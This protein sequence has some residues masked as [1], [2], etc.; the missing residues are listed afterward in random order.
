MRP[1]DPPRVAARV[2]VRD[3]GGEERDI[4]IYSQRHL[5]TQSLIDA[6]RG[7]ARVAWAGV[8]PAAV[9]TGSAALNDIVGGAFMVS[10]DIPPEL[11]EIDGLRF[12]IGE[13]PMEA[14]LFYAATLELHQTPWES[15]P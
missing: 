11:G 9:R 10:L 14:P 12:S 1:G 13:G 15:S 5:L 7:P 3:T 8:Y 6:A 2:R 4:E